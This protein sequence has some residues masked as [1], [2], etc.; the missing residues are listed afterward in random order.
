[1]KN[2]ERYKDDLE[3]IITAGKELGLAM[4]YGQRSEESKKALRKSL[5]GVIS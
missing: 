1:M 2:F 4:D 5:G 3:R